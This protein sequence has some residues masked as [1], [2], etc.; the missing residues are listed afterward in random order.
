MAAE[1][2][3]VTKEERAMPY[4]SVYV[5]ASDVIED[6]STSDLEQEL[7]S[8]RGNKG[9]RSPHSADYAISQKA[10]RYTLEEAADIFRKMGRNDLAFKL[11][12]IRTDFVGH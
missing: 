1:S 3:Q 5:D 9:E 10:A 4:V 8:R 2:K 12:E 11:E 6:I 7:R